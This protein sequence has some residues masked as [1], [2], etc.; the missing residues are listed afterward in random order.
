MP[1]VPRLGLGELAAAVHRDGLAEDLSHSRHF[2]LSAVYGAKDEATRKFDNPSIVFR[3][4]RARAYLGTR[5]RWHD[6]EVLRG[7]SQRLIHPWKP[8]F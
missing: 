7:G 3:S 5:S 4:F 1:V 2:R 6:S 8:R